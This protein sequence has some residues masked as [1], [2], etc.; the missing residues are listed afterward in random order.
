MKRATPKGST[1]VCKSRLRTVSR[2]GSIIVAFTP[3]PSR[4]HRYTDTVAG[5]E[6]CRDQSLGNE[7]LGPEHGTG[8]LL[9]T[10][11]SRAL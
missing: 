11:S 1:K 7:V 10:V 3:L 9:A 2:H 8:N 6:Q 4:I 5:T